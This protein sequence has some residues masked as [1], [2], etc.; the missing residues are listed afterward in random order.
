MCVHTI[1]QSCQCTS[2]VIASYFCLNEE[3]ESFIWFKG[4]GIKRRGSSAELTVC[5]SCNYKHFLSIRDSIRWRYIQMQNHSKIFHSPP[6]H[7]PLL[8]PSWTFSSVQ[9]KSGL[10]WITVCLTKHWSKCTN[11]TAAYTADS[12]RIS[13]HLEWEVASLRLW[14]PLSGSSGKADGL[15]SGISLPPV[16]TRESG[17]G[18][19]VS[20]P[21]W[22]PGSSCHGIFSL[23]LKAPVEDAVLLWVA[24]KEVASMPLSVE[25]P[26][27]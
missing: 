12:N 1:K 18:G 25:V 7:F 16:A 23:A 22:L 27:R 13:A 14:E 5:I 10:Q 24:V 11:S 17:V 2:L 26:C 6:F 4:S 15:F 3:E 19:E 9:G 8:I 20:V 21:P